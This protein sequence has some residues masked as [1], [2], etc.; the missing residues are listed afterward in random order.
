MIPTPPGKARG[1]IRSKTAHLP[2]APSGPTG[3][4]D[5]PIRHRIYRQAAGKSMNAVKTEGFPHD[6]PAAAVFF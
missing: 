6:E 1:E 2:V 5:T 3:P 4:R